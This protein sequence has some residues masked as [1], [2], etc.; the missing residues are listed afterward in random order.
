MDMVKFAAAVCGMP[1]PRFAMTYCSQCG[2]E[3]GPGDAGHSSCATHRPKVKRYSAD[4]DS[5]VSGIPCG[6]QVEHVHITRGNF[7]PRAETPEEYHGIRDIEFTVLDSKGYPAPWLQAKLT[8]DEKVRIEDE[9]L[10]SL[11]EE[12]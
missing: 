8:D 2:R 6:I 10:E 12:V 3:T 1:Q 4:F 9:I 7:S 11:K 5:T